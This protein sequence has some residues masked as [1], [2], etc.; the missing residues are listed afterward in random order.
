[1]ITM[2]TYEQDLGQMND[3]TGAL[4][5][6]GYAGGNEGNN[7]EGVNNHDMQNVKGVGP[8]PCG[9]YT[10]GEP[11]LHSKLGPFAIPLIPDPAN[12][13]FGRG[14]FYCHGDTTPSGNA[15]EGC[16]IMPRSVREA[17]WASDDHTLSV[18][19]SG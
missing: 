11:V 12:E 10:F 13:M 8:L 17:M 15:S 14:S 9:T 5:G 19:V 2:W 3:P 1:M 18:Q 4:A 7:P 16:I 6:N